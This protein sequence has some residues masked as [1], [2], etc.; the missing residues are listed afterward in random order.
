MT[1]V[2]VPSSNLRRHSD[3]DSNGEVQSEDAVDTP[4][5]FTWSG[6]YMRKLG[7]PEVDRNSLK[8]TL[9]ST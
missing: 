6:A 7:V 2:V 1:V 8:T 9:R 5:C 3:D 4:V